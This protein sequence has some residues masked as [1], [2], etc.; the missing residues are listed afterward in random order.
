MLRRNLFAVFGLV[1][2]CLANTGHTQTSVP[3]VPIGSTWRYLDNGSDQGI[4]WRVPEF[5]DQSWAQGLAELGYGDGNEA[6]V[7]NGGPVGARFITTYFRRAFT[8]NDAAS[9]TALTLSLLRDDGAVVYLNGSEVFRSNMP[10][11]AISYLTHALTSIADQNELIFINT[12]ISRT[13]LVSGINVLAVEIH[14]FESTSSDI[15]FNLGLVATFAPGPPIIVTEPVDR[16]VTAGRSASFNVVAQGDPPLRYQW[17]FNGAEIEGATNATLTL[18]NVT[19]ADEGS[20][21]VAVSNPQGSTPS[22]KAHLTIRPAGS[23]PSVLLIWDSS[24]EGTPGLKTALEDTGIEVTL[25]Y[26]SEDFYNG[27]NPAPDEFDVVVHLNG[28]THSTDM[29]DGGQQAL[30]RHVQEGGGY[31]G[32]E[33]NG[34][35]RTQG[36]MQLMRDLILLDRADGGE[37]SFT[38]TTV[39]AESSHPILNNV[40]T[41]FTFSGGVSFA[42]A[43]SF[44]IDPVTVLMRQPGFGTNGVLADAVAVREFGLGRIISFHHAGNYN[45]F[46]YHTLDDANIRQL[47]IDGVFWCAGFGATNP[48]VISIPPT[49]QTNFVGTTATFNVVAKGGRPFSYQWWTE[50]APIPDATNSTL[51]LQNLATTQAGA[52]WVVVSNAAGSVT[53][54]AATLTVRDETPFITQQPAANQSVL[55]GT[56]VTLSVSADGSRPLSYQWEFNSAPV[57]NATNATLILTGVT[58]GSSGIYRVTVTNARGS[59]QSDPANLVVSP[60]SL[61]TINFDE[62]TAP[63]NFSDTTRL[64][65]RYLSLGVLFEGP[66]G[67][68]GAAIVHECGNWSVSGHSSPHFLGFNAGAG[69]LGGGTPQGPETLRFTVPTTSVS[70]RVGSFT[71]GFVTMIAYDA[72]NVQLASR[73]VSLSTTMTDLEINTANIARVVISSTASAFVV[74]DLRFISGPTAPMIVTQPANR[75]VA[76]DGTA[77]FQVEAT[78]TSPLRYEWDFNGAPIPGATNSA[79]TLSGVTT[80][81]SGSYRVRIS[82]DYG[83]VT[84][85]KASLTVIELIGEVFRISQLSTDNPFAI[86]HVSLTD[87]DHGG[88][89]T[90]FNSVLVTGDGSTARFDAA[91]LG[92]GTRLNVLYN[93]LVSDLKT[94]KVYVLANGDTPIF[95]NGGIANALL[96][97]DGTTGLLTTNHI[98]L[99]AS[100][101]LVQGGGNVGFFAGYGRIVV[102]NG[103][104][105]YSIHPPSG[106][107]TDLGPMPALTHTS[108]ETWAFWGVAEFFDNAVWLVYVRDPQTIVRTRV[109]D[110]VTLTVG[111]FE[112]LSDMASITLSIPLNRWYFHHEGTSQFHSGDE[113]LGYADATFSN[114]Q[115]PSPPEILLQPRDR[116]VREGRDIRL[117]VVAGGYPISYQWRFN[118]TE[119][120][121]AT[122]GFLSLTGVT[123]SQA[124]LY[125]VIVST[126]LGTVTSSNALLTVLDPTGVTARAAILGAPSSPDWNEDVRN[127]IEDSGLFATVDLF[128]AGVEDSVPTLNQLLTYGAVLVYSDTGFYD[129]TALGNLLADYVEGGGGVALCT[130][131]LDQDPGTALGGRFRSGAYLPFPPANANGGNHLR[132]V[133]D[134]PAHP[135]LNGVDSLDGGTSSYHHMPGAVTVNTVLVAHWSN[136][137]P[138]IGA[139]EAGA[140][141]VVGLNFFPPS[142]DARADFWDASTDGGQLMA[143]A[144]FWA[145]RGQ[146]TPTPPQIRTQPV[147]QIALQ[148]TTVTFAVRAFGSL[149]LAYQWQHN[150]IPIP[151]GT[152]RTLLLTDVQLSDSGGYRVVVTNALGPVTSVMATL[153]VREPRGT[154]AFFTDYSSASTSMVASIV[155][156]LH[157][158][159]QVEDIRTFDLARTDILMINELGDIP[160]SDLRDRFP[161]LQDWVSRGGRLIVHQ[162]Y[163]NSQLLEANPFLLGYRGARFA[164]TSITDID[165]VPPGNTLVTDGPHGTLSNTSL[166]A[167]NFALNNA[168]FRST[169]PASHTS[170][171]GAGQ[172]P[173]QIIAFAYGLGSGLIYH[174]TFPLNVYLDNPVPLST[175]VREVYAPNV[176]EYAAAYQASG[177][178]VIFEDPDDASAFTGGSATFTVSVRGA[179][180]LSFQWFV[181]GTAL[182]GATNPTLVLTDLTTN[183]AGAYHVEVGNAEGMAT[184]SEATLTLITAKTFKVVSLNTTGSRVVDHDSITSDDRGGIA[185]SSNRV[186]YTGDAQTA[187][188]SAVDLSGGTGLGRHYDALVSNLRTEQ[189]YSLANGTTLLSGGGG[190]V[191]GLIEINGTNGNLTANR[192]AFSSDIPLFGETGIFAGYDCIALHNGQRVYRIEIPSGLVT[193]LGAMATPNHYGCENWAYWGVTEFFEGDVYLAYVQHYQSIARTRVPDGFTQ[194]LSS[195]SNLSDMCSFT[196]SLSRNRWYFHHEGSSQFGGSSETIGYANA[197]WDKPPRIATM[198]NMVVNE[199]STTGFFS[200]TI[201]DL[202][203][204]PNQVRVTAT[205]SNTLILPQANVTLVGSNNTSRSLSLTPAPNQFGTSIVTITVTDVIGQSTNRVFALITL[206]VNDPPSFTRGANQSVLEDS[207]KHTV[208]NWA[209][210]LSAGPA[211]ESDQ[212]LAFQLTTDTPS[213]FAVQPAVSPEGELTFTPAPNAVGSATVQV[214]LV[215]GGGT[216]RG[217]NDTSPMQQF[218]ITVTPVNDP[219]SFLLGTSPVVLEDSGPQIFSGWIASLSAGPP[220]ETGQTFAFVV[221]HENP[222][223]FAAAPALAPDGTLTFTPTPNAHGTALVTA[224]LQ[225]NGGTANGGNDLSPPQTFLIT[226]APVNDPP[227]ANIQVV[228]L[229]EDSSV[230]VILGGFD[231]DG[232]A[233]AYN[234]VTPP[235]HGTLGGL[236]ANRTYVPDP[237]YVGPD[238]FT[239]LAN[240]GALDSA[241]A[242]VSLV[243]MPINDAP[244][245]VKGSDQSVPED[246]GPQSAVNW[247]TGIQAGQDN[248]S[249]QTVDFIVSHTNPSLFSTAP[250]ITPSGTLTYTPAPNAHGS[251]LV[252]VVLHDNGGVLNGGENSSGPQTFTIIVRPVNDPPLAHAQSLQVDENASLTV[253]LTGSDLENDLLTFVIVTSP[254]HGTLAGAGPNR[255]YTPSA[256]YTGLDQFTFKANDGQADSALATVDLTI[257]EVNDPPVA[258]AHAS[259]LLYLIPGST[260]GVVFSSNGSNAWVVLDGSLSYDPEGSPLTYAWYLGSASVPFATGSVVSNLFEVGLFEVVLQVDDG[261]EVGRQSLTVEVNTLGAA[262][263]Q[264]AIYLGQSGLERQRKGPLLATLK[265]IFASFERGNFISGQNQLRAFQNKVRAQV[266]SRDPLLAAELIRQSELIMSVVTGP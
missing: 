15:S 128:F 241:P 79:L 108:S 3:I 57:A 253:T 200:F 157:T 96:E 43:H 153:D 154:V 192:I 45:H 174:S 195:F 2:F 138:L 186:F 224:R 232:D 182:P 199:D 196:I 156:S 99:S 166:D 221:S 36:R 24:G 161:A 259:P 134:E 9:V 5:D 243:I 76:L 19:T 211:N 260:N 10:G 58:P 121:D 205:S 180:P 114:S 176:L 100:I 183:S 56:T 194:I 120:G 59:T 90:S 164:F 197:V 49:D 240:D 6:T 142:S 255:T 47:Y 126:P 163:L 122:N 115:E 248:E 104:W 12:D 189:I 236:G 212:S 152:N 227:V 11:G 187:H 193:D 160:S 148:G 18:S 109:P 130:F 215:D 35:E 29:P 42:Q 64:T 234:I 155:R 184:S 32:G 144:L 4:E 112:N 113:T 168:A 254:A 223:L 41:T 92:N 220:D 175:V 206:P 171:L 249:A 82:N 71:S 52:Y 106:L 242:T 74:D 226:V 98:N 136:G 167:G 124:G 225:D 116:V 20:Y 86:E 238:S 111:E 261:A 263:E 102:H 22:R 230:N 133:T 151:N 207:G 105:T 25:S 191:N 137:Q 159:L 68:D 16:T 30:V 135:I 244:R 169:L 218:M 119:I 145:A 237:N 140:G 143:N 181:N 131:A 203:T 129:S 262:V 165:V 95:E 219:P 173:E 88:I 51:V 170:I 204:P 48:P 77:T 185:V 7:V 70:L 66:G 208:A 101:S 34:F 91:N 80:D 44:A 118:G 265:A 78:G 158:P 217:G 231:L 198:T 50:T 141:R 147:D 85:V 39:P 178:P 46:N 73:T 23:V 53:S 257:R 250:M 213:L 37:G 54:V 127:K 251:S 60:G 107:V 93:S 67:L 33:W 228:T 38:L 150:E 210:T 216:E 81:D 117:E 177:P 162:Q 246:A 123:S 97:I 188:F 83:S 27:S 222:G 40:P 258:V 214:V 146:L 14:Q 1:L 125:S 266:T 94:G 62:A 256:G 75:I 69:L 110:G 132:L 190:V 179:G 55:N 229:A 63:C 209:T 84:S 13:S 61:V 87:D 28:T 17:D 252:T 72:N 89:A 103:T 247:A 65:T 264:L 8:V 139:R 239:F 233:L 245:F 31:I 149:P 235:A 202:E 201:Q 21:R 172:D 26:T